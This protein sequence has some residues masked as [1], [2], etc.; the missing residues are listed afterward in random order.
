MVKN[1]SDRHIIQSY[2][3]KGYA[4]GYK[5]HK[6]HSDSQKAEDDEYIYNALIVI[7]VFC[8]LL[9][10]IVFTYVKNAG[11]NSHY[12]GDCLLDL[13]TSY[14]PRDCLVN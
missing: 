6:N 9:V 14:Q 13:A 3:Q 4:H 11:G 2:Y 12:Q 7:S 8:I 10:T 1:N 5:R